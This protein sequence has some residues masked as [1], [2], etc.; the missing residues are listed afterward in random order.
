MPAWDISADMFLS[1]RETQ[2]LLRSVRE[3][4][5]T[6]GG[7]AAVETLA[8]R[9]I[10]ETLLFSGIRTSECCR[11]TV[12]DVRI[13][14]DEP[15]LLVRGPAGGG[16]TVFIPA[17]LAGLLQRYA[18]AVHFRGRDAILNASASRRPFFLNTRGRAL[19]RTTLYRRVV[20]ILTR[21]G[22]GERA[23]VQLLRHT[24]G[25]LAYRH[26]GGNLL[27]VQRQLGHAH[28]MI[29][30]VYAQFVEESYRTIAN[31]VMAACAPRERSARRRSHKGAG[32]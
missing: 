22:L 20:R 23:S 25:L 24:Y 15:A 21:A 6:A 10:V 7:P 26:S 12:A 13:D 14:T 27:F 3:A 4:E 18:A 16:R 32:T 29:T 5:R 19:D 2:C 9:A 30:A 17:A 11:L 1:E 8:D 28:P 31:Q